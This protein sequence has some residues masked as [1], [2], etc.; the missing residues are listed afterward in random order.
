MSKTV[1]ERLAI[2]LSVL[3]IGVIVIFWLAQVNDVMETLCLAYGDF[4]LE[5]PEESRL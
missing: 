5:E 2:A 3:F 1:L 4:C